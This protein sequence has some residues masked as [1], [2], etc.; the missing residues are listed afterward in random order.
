MTRRVEEDT[1]GRTRLN[2]GFASTEGKH[3]LLGHVEVTHVDVDVRL[4]WSFAAGPLWRLMVRCELERECDTAVA[5]QL[6]PII[7]STLDLLARDSA[8]ERS[9]RA[10]IPAVEGNYAKSSDRSHERDSCTRAWACEH[11][12]RPPAGEHE[13]RIRSPIRLPKRG[14]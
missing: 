12:M 13:A 8:V 6:H 11:R 7:V 5:A 2:L 14:S 9:Q 10:G 1:K 3:L 4:L